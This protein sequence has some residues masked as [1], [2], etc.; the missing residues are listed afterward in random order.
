MLTTTAAFS[1]GLLV[2]LRWPGLPIAGWLAALLVVPVARFLN[3]LTIGHWL[4]ALMLSAGVGAV[5]W[6]G[7]DMIIVSALA[8][9]EILAFLAV[10][11]TAA[12]IDAALAAMALAG[13]ARG[14]SLR[15]WVGRRF[16]VRRLRAR[17]TRR[18]ARKAAANDDDPAGAGGV[19]SSD[20]ATSVIP[21]KAGIS[22]G[23]CATRA[24]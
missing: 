3:G 12:L 11:D 24:A 6:M 14:L 2:L 16:G 8:S 17:R 7:G 18:V 4:L 20:L 22:W 9:P 10:V 15:H 5:A 21:A 13:A 1:I 19:R 23:E